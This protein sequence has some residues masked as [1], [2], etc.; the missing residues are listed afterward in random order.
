MAKLG[1]YGGDDFEGAIK[2]LEKNFEFAADG[3]TTD[4]GGGRQHHFSVGGLICSV[5][6]QFTGK[7]IGA[8]IAGRLV[9]VE[10]PESH[11]EHLGDNFQ[12]KVIKGTINWL[13]HM[14]SDVAGSS[15]N[16]GKGTGVP[17]PHPFVDQAAVPASYLQGCPYVHGEGGG[18]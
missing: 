17:G 18:R 15:S 10:I 5:F 13:F 3:K 9:T 1:G 7:A 14:V 8:D 4:F 2:H 11:V 12:E 16:P 6:I